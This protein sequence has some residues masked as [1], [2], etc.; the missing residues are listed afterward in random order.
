[1][2]KNAAGAVSRVTGLIKH[3]YMPTDCTELPS[4]L[5]KQNM[6]THCMMYQIQIQEG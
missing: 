1:M 2:N 3:K 6:H 5:F 4:P